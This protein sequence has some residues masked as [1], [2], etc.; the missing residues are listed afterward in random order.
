MDRYMEPVLGNYYTFELGDQIY[1]TRAE[2]LAHFNDI[3]KVHLYKGP[4]LCFKNSV[5]NDKN[6]LLLLDTKSYTISESTEEEIK[7]LKVWL[8][9]PIEIEIEIPP[10]SEELSNTKLFKFLKI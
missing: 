6:G 9:E 4:L 10:M 2:E 1:I 5:A 7:L 8:G 3:Y